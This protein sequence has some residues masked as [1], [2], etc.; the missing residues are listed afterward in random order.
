MIYRV[1]KTKIYL[2]MSAIYR[3]ANLDDQE[4]LICFF[5]EAYGSNSALA[6]KEYLNW[7]F[8]NDGKPY[9]NNWI[10]LI[11]NKIVSHYGIIKT[12]FQFN[13]Q[14][15]DIY[16]GVNS[17][18]LP[19]YR[20]KSISSII[21]NQLK[22]DIPN[23]VVIGF[24]KKTKEFYKK[25]GFNLHEDR[26]FE[27]FVKVTNYENL[28]SLCSINLEDTLQEVINDDYSHKYNMVRITLSNFH[29]GLSSG[30]GSGL[31][32]SKPAPAILPACRASI[33]AS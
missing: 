7:F 22:S 11:D 12:E 14:E 4:K 3:K 27:R 20:G 33:S 15:F 29:K 8:F 16:F 1:G 13:E 30:N 18:T 21:F 5:S 28:S 17:F 23:L 2:L 10:A 24:S 31:S 19:N 25:N 6:N 32:T 9:Q 26:R